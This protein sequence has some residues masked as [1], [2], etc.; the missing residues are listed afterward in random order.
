MN[1]AVFMQST[2]PDRP[3]QFVQSDPERTETIIIGLVA[4][5]PSRV[6][7]LFRAVSS[8]ALQTRS[9]DALVIVS[10]GALI[11]D[12]VEDALRRLLP[13]CTITFLAN[14]GMRGAA[15]T[16]NKGIQFIKFQWSNAYVAILDD[17]DIWDPV[18]IETCE[19]KARL[20]SWPDAVVSGLQMS[21]DGEEVLR[22][23]LLSASVED[24]LAGNPGWQ[25]SNTFVR[26]DALV[27]AG[28]FTD[29]L[30]SCN[31]RDLAIRLLTRKGSRVAFTGRHTATWFLDATRQS[32]SSR[33]GEAKRA[34]LARFYELHG[35]RMDDEI[36]QRF[37]DRARALFGWSESEILGM[38]QLVADA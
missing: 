3:M 24:F 36:R 10:D 22:D 27:A 23:P 20:E 7:S 26:L 11:P 13:S 8:M 12:A 21:I 1:G 29:G 30:R 5:L 34:G 18:H 37:F 32:L 17:D 14:H 19:A 6:S 35:H 2:L 33:R 28:C 16:W 25:G 4:T 31:D 15:E 9:L 38:S